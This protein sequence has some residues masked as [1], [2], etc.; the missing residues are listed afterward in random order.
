MNTEE[1]KIILA[2]VHHDTD[3][4]SDNDV[5]QAFALLDSDPELQAWFEQEQAFDAAVSTKLAQIDPPADLKAN[6]VALLENNAPAAAEDKITWLRP[7]LMA[8]AAAVLLISFFAIQLLTGPAAASFDDF[9]TEMVEIA[10]GELKL[11]HEDKELENLY[12]YLNKMEATCPTSL[13]VCVECTETVGC[14]V[15]GW[16]DEEDSVTLICIRNNASQV[17]HC[18][19]IPRSEFKKLPEE[20]IIRSNQ[21]IDGLETTAWSDDELVYLLI[22]SKE[23]VK[24]KAPELVEE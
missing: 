2:S 22:G 17:V 10:R 20:K 7:P 4:G 14:K 13:P 18:F 15:I 9:R 3:R 1:A 5:D 12:D 11:D 6:L 16:N 23:G 8:A 24:V 21:M 19:V